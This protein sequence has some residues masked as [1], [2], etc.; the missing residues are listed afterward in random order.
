MHTYTQ[1]SEA[2]RTAPGTAPRTASGTAPRRAG[3]RSGSPP[4]SC[5][6]ASAPSF[7]PPRPACSH[8]NRH[9]AVTTWRCEPHLAVILPSPCGAVFPSASLRASLPPSSSR[10]PSLFLPPPPHPPAASHASPWCVPPGGVRIVTSFLLVPMRLLWVGMY[11]AN[12]ARHLQAATPPRQ[13]TKAASQSP[14]PFTGGQGAAVGRRL[15]LGRQPSP[16]GNAIYIY[17]VFPSTLQSYHSA[18]TGRGGQKDGAEARS[19]DEGDRCHTCPQ[20]SVEPFPM[21]SVEPSPGQCASL[22][23]AACRCAR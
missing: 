19:Q 23:S 2:R 1:P 12:T 11:T 7:C 4:S 20:P 16:S 13:V 5:V 21:L 10:R 15:R 9:F 14:E 18:P 3:G 22:R 6:L 8:P 17:N